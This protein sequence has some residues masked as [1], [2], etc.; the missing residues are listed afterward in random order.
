M[1]EEEVFGQLSSSEEEDEN[2][3]FK[4]KD[5]LKQRKKYERQMKRATEKVQRYMKGKEEKEDGTTGAQV[6]KGARHE[7]TYGSGSETES[8]NE[9]MLSYDATHQAVIVS[10]AESVGKLKPLLNNRSGSLS[11]SSS[12]SSEEGVENGFDGLKHSRKMNSLLNEQKR[13]GIFSID[14]K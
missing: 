6:S 13:K 8:E 10:S 12:S 14:L 9:E 3:V 1:I 2:K 5:K 11:N 4:L 7:A